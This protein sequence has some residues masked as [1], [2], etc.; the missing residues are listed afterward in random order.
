[1]LSSTYI[2]FYFFSQSKYA[3]VEFESDAAVQ[4][5]LVEKD[6]HV[7]DGHQLVVKAR[8]LS[9]EPKE[10]NTITKCKDTDQASAGVVITDTLIAKLSNHKDVSSVV[11]IQIYF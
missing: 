1:M 9:D 2:Y 10:K 11:D 5:L 3:I 7:L 6:K 4:S 8:K